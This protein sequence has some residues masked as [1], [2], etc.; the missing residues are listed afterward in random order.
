MVCV[1][2]LHFVDW[3]T[4]RVLLVGERGLFEVRV[5]EHGTRRWVVS[6]EAINVVPVIPVEVIRV[7]RGQGEDNEECGSE[8]VLH[9][10]VVDAVEGVCVEQVQRG[11]RDE[12]VS[13]DERWL[14]EEAVRGG[15]NG[16]YGCPGV[17]H[18]HVLGPLPD[19]QEEE[20]HED[21]RRGEE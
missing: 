20:D 15:G 19:E 9:M 16:G 17:E 7:V 1:A 11:C 10:V 14:E 12:E 6:E 4:L 5:E 3:E 13:V 2:S 8:D 21:D 18:A